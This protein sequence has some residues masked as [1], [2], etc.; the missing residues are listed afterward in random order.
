MAPRL[1]ISYRR[2]R[3]A[4]VKPAVESLRAGGID[5]FLDVDDID[6]LADFPERI[7]AGVAESHGLLA[8][9]SDD[10]AE[11][12]HCLAEFKL[13]WKRARRHDPDVGRRVFVLNPEPRS[14]HV[15][16]ADLNA[17]NFLKPPQPGAETAWAQTLATRLQQLLPDGPLGSEEPVDAQPAHFHLPAPTNEFTGRT[18]ELLRIHAKL[19]PPQIGPACLGGAVQIHGLGG[20]GK[21]ELAAKYA[22]DF[23]YAYPGGIVWLNLAGYQPINPA[24]CEEAEHAW[25]EA[26]EAALRGDADLLYDEDGKP[27]A[28]ARVRRTLTERFSGARSYLWVL[29]NVPVLLPESEREKILAFW[30][31]PSAA[32][33]TLVTTRDSRRAAGFEELPLDVLRPEDGLRL[34][35]RY[36]R[37]SHAEES[38]ARQMVNT[39]GGHSLALTLLGEQLRDAQGNYARARERLKDRALLERIEAI[40]GDLRA[41]A[42]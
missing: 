17:K 4:E 19:H 3:L 37:P 30:R 21:T 29:D 36:R 41:R 2:S 20:V 24:R 23:A 27:L 7:R 34:L 5:C 1:F 26:V 38:I 35:A 9:W 12:D 39:V 15:C 14:D 25:Y 40:A 6:P 33:R 18:A 11:S 28:P 22:N 13:A 16:A 42:R 10:Y 32:G 31:A 8:W